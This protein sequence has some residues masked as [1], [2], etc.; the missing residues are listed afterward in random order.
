MDGAGTVYG[1][2]TAL[3]Y[4]TP[5]TDPARFNGTNVSY[6]K[7]HTPVPKIYQW[8]L[9]IQRQ[10]SADLM[11][12]VS[13]VGSHG[14][15]LA[16]QTDLNAI[17]A[18]KLSANDAQYRPYPQF[19]S[20]VGSNN[21]GISNYNSLQASITKRMS[22]GL[23]LTFNYV[24]AHFLDSQDSAGWGGGGTQHWQIAN[25][26]AANYSNSNF[27]VRHAIKGY[28]VYELPFGKGKRVLN[29]SALLDEVVGGW[30]VSGTLY[31]ATGQPFTV[32]G[33]QNTYQLAA[34]QE[35]YP[36]RVPGVSTK[37]THQSTHCEASSNATTGCMN[38]WYNPAAFSQPADGTFGNVRRNSLHG[39][40][41]G[42]VNLSGGKT[43]ALPYEGIKLEFRAD[44]TN[45]LNHANFSEPNGNLG[46]AANVGG[47]YSWSANTQQI[48]GT[49]FGGRAL[50]MQLRLKF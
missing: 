37:P 38:E 40:G 20:I 19:G 11:A 8:N 46:G 48:S 15:N 22:S 18:T 13:Y 3:P 21:Q 33:T 35:V 45:A 10:L 26:D 29:N 1:T 23:S 32:L 41:I 49:S 31:L 14:Y 27:D 17:P 50:Q 34:N 25:N 43:F 36:N 42:Q 12:E 5:S 7:Y 47:A 6:D 24:W 44:A 39:P 4:S 9:A 30:Q 2:S 16:D 28:A